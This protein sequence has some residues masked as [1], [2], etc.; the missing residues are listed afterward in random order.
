MNEIR[1]RSCDLEV[2]ECSIGIAPKTFQDYFKRVAH[3]KCT[4]ANNMN[5]VLPNIRTEPGKKSFAYQGAILSN[6]LPN[7]LKTEQ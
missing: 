2:F 1:N 7:D 6:K 4:R 5:I 3:A